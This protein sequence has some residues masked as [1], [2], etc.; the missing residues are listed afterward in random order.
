MQEIKFRLANPALNADLRNLLRRAEPVQARHQRGVQ[1][2]GHRLARGWSSR[3]CTLGCLL[4][5]DFYY[6]LCHLFYKQRDTV[7]TFYNVVSDIC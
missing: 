3:N 4:T 5:F 2:R 7:G 6:C 1:C